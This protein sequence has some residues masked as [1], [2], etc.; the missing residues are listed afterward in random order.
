MFR[1]FVIGA[2]GG[3]GSRLA[4][5][6]IER[7][8]QVVGLHRRPEQA[9][10]LESDGMEPVLG[11]LTSLGVDT[12]AACLEGADAVVFTAG[13]SG[14]GPRQ[15][16][17][18]DGQGVEIA[19]T[20]A[21]TAGVRRFLLVSAF[22]DAW[23]DR[24]MPPNFEH[25]MK[26]KRQAD[27]L[28]AATDLDWVIVRPGT[29][30]NDPGTGHIRIGV[31]IPYGDVPRDDVAAVLTELVHQPQVN[32]IILELTEGEVPIREALDTLEKS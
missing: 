13:A 7:G 15:A 9:H 6:L 20:A 16:D 18:V 30:T 14:A 10:A 27:V 19:A 32:R 4:A 29:L 21:A 1:V 2:T 28:L 24:R 11:D 3:V 12:L 5:Q 31:A 22:P 17:A 23:R 8:D 25:Y 26:V